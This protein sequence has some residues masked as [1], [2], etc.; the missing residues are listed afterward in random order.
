MESY[1]KQLHPIELNA[2]TGEP[3]L[4]LPEPHTNI[5][6]TPPRMSDV[7]FVVE[8]LNDPR[9]YSNLM[10]PPFPYLE[11]HAVYWL[12]SVI[13]PADAL[14]KELKEHAEAEPESTPKIVGGCPVRILREVQPDGTE[15]Y[16]GDLGVSRCG[17]PHGREGADRERLSAENDAREVGDES[18]VWCLG[19]MPCSPPFDCRG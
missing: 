10:G 12:K 8:N 14:L 9:V 6:L 16:L 4:R 19:G 17:F 15:L 7:P 1:L 11:E 5:I 18:I 2:Q 3:F 13:G